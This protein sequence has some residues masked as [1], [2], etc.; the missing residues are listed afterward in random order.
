MVREFSRWIPQTI[1]IEWMDGRMETMDCGG[2]CDAISVI[3]DCLH[4]HRKNGQMAPL[5]TLMSVPLVNIR[6]WKLGSSDG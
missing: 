1:R 3:D 4:V 2:M 5:E 6:N